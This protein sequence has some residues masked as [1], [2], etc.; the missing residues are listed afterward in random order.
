MSIEHIFRGVDNYEHE[1]ELLIRNGAHV[2]KVLNPKGLGISP[3]I[4]LINPKYPHNVGAAIRIASCYGITQVWYTGNRV[5]LMSNTIRVPRE[6]RMSQ[7]ADVTLAN[8][9]RPFDQFKDI[10]PVAVEMRDNAENLADFVHPSNPVY[11]FGPEDGDLGR[12]PLM[13]CHRFIKI[14]TKHCL[15]LSAAIATV[16]YDRQAKG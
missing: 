14:Q 12:I 4:I 11:V 10:T 2:R 8:Y 13:H 15:N 5:K 7:Y 9:D 16:L 1:T 6:E 3:A